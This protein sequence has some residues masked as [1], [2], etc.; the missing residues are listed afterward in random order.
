MGRQQRGRAVLRSEVVVAQAGYGVCMCMRVY[1]GVEVTDSRA[2]PKGALQEA[3]DKDSLGKFLSLVLR[4]SSV[5][6]YCLSRGKKK[7]NSK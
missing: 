7:K 6:H 4:H 3:I 1:A 5:I 2:S